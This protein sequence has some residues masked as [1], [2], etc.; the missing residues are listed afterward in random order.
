MDFFLYISF[1]K[2]SY[3]SKIYYYKK[4]KQHYFIV[5]YEILQAFRKDNDH[6]SIYN[7]RFIITLS[8]NVQWKGGSLSLGNN[9][10]YITLSKKRMK[11]ID[12]S[13]G[14]EILVELEKDTS[15]YGLEVP[16]EFQEL[17]N[18]D[19][20][21]K[22]RFE[23]ISMGKQRS[24]I[25]IVQQLKSSQKRIEKSIFLLENLKRA[26]LGGETMRHILGKDLS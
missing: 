9:Q 11:E 13:L 20:E 21:A 16:P 18:Q 10:A 1:V 24:T 4:L 23:K 19:T 7:Q 15:K 12:V 25:Y 22:S 17:L 2:K 5:P 26:P 8:K 3:S 6:G 14:D